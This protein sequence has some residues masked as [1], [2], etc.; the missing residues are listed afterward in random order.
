MGP[1]LLLIFV[2]FIPFTPGYQ[3][4]HFVGE[5]MRGVDSIAINLIIILQSR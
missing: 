1:K 5:A 4:Q 3:L 2:I